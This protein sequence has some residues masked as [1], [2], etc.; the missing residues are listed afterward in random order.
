MNISLNRYTGIIIQARTQ[1]TRLKN[2]TILPFYHDLTMLEV[3]LT[4]LKSTFNSEQIVV[5]TTDNSFDDELVKIVKAQGI[6]VFRGNETNVLDRFIK[7]A[8]K[9]KFNEIVRICSDN[10]FLNTEYLNQLIHSYHNIS[11]DYLSFID[12]ETPVIKT[13]WGLF[14]EIFKLSTL[15]KV[16]K[17][18]NE[19]LYIEHVT[20][21]IYSNKDVFN[22]SFLPLPKELKEFPTPLRLTVDDEID[23]SIAS[24]IYK[25]LKSDSQN[26]TS[27]LKYVEQHPSLLTSINKQYKK[28][29]K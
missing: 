19:K 4:N 12:N 20:N 26:I 10:P 15:E 11:A 18:T 28:Y 5:A 3:M 8:Y 2:K 14:G 24:S 25:A 6:S 22:C 16:K 23:F 21:Y 27:L 13:H 9:F 7:C 17:L 1:S 29:K